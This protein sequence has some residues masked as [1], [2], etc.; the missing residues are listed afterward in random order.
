MTELEERN[1]SD[2]VV[3]FDGDVPPIPSA[4][5]SSPLSSAL[6]QSR[7]FLFPVIAASFAASHVRQFGSQKSEILVSVRAATL[8]TLEGDW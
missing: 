2:R 3:R 4:P 6:Y 5:Q 1:R 8:R 7:S